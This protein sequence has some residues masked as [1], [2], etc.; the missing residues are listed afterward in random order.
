MEAATAHP[1]VGRRSEPPW[2]A[3]WL[4]GFVWGRGLGFNSCLARLK[5]WR[6]LW[7]Q[8]GPASHG[9]PRN[10]STAPEWQAIGLTV[11]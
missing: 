1:R 10:E 4:R 2:P 5:A 6:V 8:K 3:L 7:T 9:H 11:L